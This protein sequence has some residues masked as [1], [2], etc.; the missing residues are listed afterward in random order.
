MSNCGRAAPRL[1]SGVRLR[2]QPSEHMKNLV[3]LL[4]IAFAGG[5]V[6]SSIHTDSSTNHH[7]A[8]FLRAAESYAAKD[9]PYL[10]PDSKTPI[11]G[12][13]FTI[14]SFTFS[15]T[16]LT[17]YRFAETPCVGREA[18]AEELI[19]LGFKKLPPGPHG[20]IHVLQDTFRNQSNSRS[21][22][23]AFWRST[24]FQC[25]EVLFVDY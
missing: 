16:V 22:N 4:F 17:T 7:F 24:R 11:I 25:L 13:N 19:K 14:T 10:S 2:N 15:P 1:N 3:T 20:N 8:E 6:S 12:S 5:C 18:V 9:K 21:V 23:A